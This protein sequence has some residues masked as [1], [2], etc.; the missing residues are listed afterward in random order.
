M[1]STR[2]LGRVSTPLSERPL[3]VSQA[4]SLVTRPFGTHPER[5]VRDKEKGGGNSTRSGEFR[6]DEWED[7]LPAHLPPTAHGRDTVGTTRL[8]YS[9]GSGCGVFLC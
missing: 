8:L 7:S 5:K 2:C 3:D 9:A 6:G 1:K 4:S